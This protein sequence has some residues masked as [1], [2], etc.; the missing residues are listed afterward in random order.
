[1][2]PGFS[3]TRNKHVKHENF[4]NVMLGC[5]LYCDISLSDFVYDLLTNSLFIPSLS[6]VYHLQNENESSHHSIHQDFSHQGVN[7]L[8]IPRSNR[9]SLFFDE[10]CKTGHPDSESRAVQHNLPY[11]PDL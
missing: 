6:S 1:M 9:P 4:I 2:T 5:S 10:Y 11:I 3:P 8:Y 7:H